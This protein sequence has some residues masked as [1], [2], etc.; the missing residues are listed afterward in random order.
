MANYSFKRLNAAGYKEEMI[1]TDEPLAVDIKSP[2]NIWKFNPISGIKYD[3][4]KFMKGLSES[5]IIQIN[6]V[7]NSHKA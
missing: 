2:V 3:L 4:E 7:I 1:L 6:G 5:E